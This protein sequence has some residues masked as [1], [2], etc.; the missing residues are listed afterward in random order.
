MYLPEC[1][2]LLTLAVGKVQPIVVG[3]PAVKNELGTGELRTSEVGW[4]GVAMSNIIYGY[5][6]IY[7]V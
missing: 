6:L 2:T 1:S 3:V 7:N 4:A 5:R